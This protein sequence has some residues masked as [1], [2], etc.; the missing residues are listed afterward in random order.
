MKNGSPFLFA[1]TFLLGTSI[2][3]SAQSQFSTE[4]YKQFRDSHRGYTATEIID[5]HPPLTTYYSSRIYPADLSA[6]PWYDSLDRHFNFTQDEQEMLSENFFMVSERLHSFDW[7]SAFIGLYSQDIPLFLSSDFV[8]STLHNSYDAILQ[9]IEW[10]FLEPNLQEMLHAMYGHFPTL[11]TRYSGDDRFTETLKDVDLYLS[12]ALSL[13]QGEEYLPQVDK[14]QKFDEV[15]AAIEA[16][17]EKDMTLFTES[18]IRHL[19]FSQF[20]PRG[21]YNKDIYTPSGVVTLGNYFRAMMWLGRIDFLM[22]APPGN[23]WEPDWTDDELR[24]MQLGALLLNEVV[25]DCGKLENLT[26]H[27]EIISFMVGPDDNMTPAELKALSNSELLSTEDLFDSETFDLFMVKLNASDDFGQKIMSNFFLVDPD[28]TDPGQLPVSYKLLGQKFLVDSYVF[29][30]V[31]YDRISFEGKKVW[32]PLPDPLD[33]MAALGNEDAFALLE[34]EMETYKYASNMA[35][36]EYLIDSY[37]ETFW[38]QSLYNTWLGAIRTLNPPES[39]DGLPYFM[40]TTAWHQK[41]L[42]TQLVSWA[43]LRHDNILYGKQSYTGGTGCSYPYTYVEPYPELYTKLADFA[44]KA[45]EF[46][47]QVFAGIEVESRDRIVEYYEAYSE[48]M[49]QLGIIAFKELDH[50]TLSEAEMTFLKTMINGYMASGPSISG[51]YTDLFFD[52]E[53]GLWM[54][55]TVADVHTQPTDENG[56]YVGNVLHVGNGK[57]NTG[58]FLAENSC[59][60]GQYMAYAGPVSSFHQQVEPN[61]NRLTDQEWEDLFWENKIPERPDWV[62]SYLVGVD[63]KKLPEGRALKGSVYTGTGIDPATEQNPMDYMI[64]FP[65]P[66]SERAALRFIL[67]K[68]G[69]LNLEVYNTSGGLVYTMVQPGLAPAEHHI[70]LPVEHWQKG[71]YL[72]RVSLGGNRVVKELVVQ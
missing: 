45:A 10:Q 65:N 66:A 27:E 21:H 25:Y 15:L 44:D 4:A 49:E 38:D 7:A 17:E 34:E 48:I 58:V 54:D 71:L 23:P 32:R 14:R 61:F 63:G 29:S 20:T 19:D 52:L 43:Q 41:K 2:W 3:A 9:T 69:D 36:L 55:Y 62:A 70:P 31:V 50:V 51:W 12:V 35:G 30:E 16:E 42:N 8:L 72:V 46:F 40:Q 22:T 37:D 67:N 64:L 1:I 57:I 18:K 68:P 11:V 24:R 39:S 59:N 60:P 47:S 33:L 13:A 28:S 56:G 5:D 53:K 6:I 26:K